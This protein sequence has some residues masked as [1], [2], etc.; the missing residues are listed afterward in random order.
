M[1]QEHD[2]ITSS[3]PLKNGGSHNPHFSIVETKAQKE[4]AMALKS[5]QESDSRQDIVESSL[6][7]RLQLEPWVQETHV[8]DV[9]A[10]G[11]NLHIGLQDVEVEGGCQHAT[12]AAPLVTSTHQEPIP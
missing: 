11:E 1:C 2:P 10:L 6:S 4:R 5:P 8:H 9:C 7:L 3:W 12:V